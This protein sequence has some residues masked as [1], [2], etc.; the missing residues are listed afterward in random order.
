MLTT[1]KIWASLELTVPSY[2]HWVI[3]GCFSPWEYALNMLNLKLDLSFNMRIGF[4]LILKWSAFGEIEFGFI[5]HLIFGGYTK[6]RI[7]FK[8][9]SLNFLWNQS[10]MVEICFIMLQLWFLLS[11]LKKKKKFLKHS[12]Y[13]PFL[14]KYTVVFLLRSYFKLIKIRNKRYKNVNI[15]S[16]L[17]TR[18]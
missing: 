3:Y 7:C 9:I 18:Q 6:I 14:K 15:N 2:L 5:K 12:C 16:V 13:L 17:V 8:A 1:F 4:M 11:N 10:A